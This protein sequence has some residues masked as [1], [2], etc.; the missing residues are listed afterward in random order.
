M[1]KKCGKMKRDKDKLREGQKSSFLSCRW[2]FYIVKKFS[3][4][5]RE[6]DKLRQRQKS[7]FL[8]CLARSMDT[9]Y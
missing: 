7:S 1:V 2:T 8:I 5:K 9:K 6:Q 3:K 4:M